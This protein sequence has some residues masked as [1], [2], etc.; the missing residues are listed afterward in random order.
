MLRAEQG[1]TYMSITT[2]LCNY[3]LYCLLGPHCA[4]TRCSTS[5]VEE[6]RWLRN[7]LTR[8]SIHGRGN[9]LTLKHADSSFN[10]RSRKHAYSK[11]RWLAF[12]CPCLSLCHNLDRIFCYQKC[13]NVHRNVH[14]SQSAKPILRARFAYRLSAS[15]H[16]LIALYSPQQRSVHFMCCIH[17][18]FDYM[19][20]GPLSAGSRAGL[21][22]KQNRTEVC[23]GYNSR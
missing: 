20:I 2:Q 15:C 9:T 14:K 3:C 23:G 13:R 22:R 18:I 4:V 21:P 17:P 6:T 7:T 5:T 8:L 11:A 1:I 10:P 19:M 16:T 12:Q